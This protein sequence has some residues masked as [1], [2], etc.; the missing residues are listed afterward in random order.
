MPDLFAEDRGVHH[1][2]ARFNA[3]V[4]A[5]LPSNDLLLLHGQLFRDDRDHD[6]VGLVNS[7]DGAGALRQAITALGLVH[8]R[9]R[10]HG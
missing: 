8:Q 3:P 6:R 1:L 5:H 9:I 4:H 10:C 7:S 2:L